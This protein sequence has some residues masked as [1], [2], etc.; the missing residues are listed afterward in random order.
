MRLAEFISEVRMAKYS[1]VDDIAGVSTDT[2]KEDKFLD[3]G[4][5]RY[6]IINLKRQ[7]QEEKVEERKTKLIYK[8]AFYMSNEEDGISESLQ[9]LEGTSSSLKECILGMEEYF[10]GN[11]EEAY[12]LLSENCD[13][14]LGTKKHFL[15]NKVYGLLLIKKKKYNK[16]IEVLK[17]A[18]ALCP[19]DI[20]CYRALEEAYYETFQQEKHEVVTDIIALLTE[21]AWEND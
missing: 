18:L 5:L 16:A 15:I 9:Y 12:E 1:I 20:E 4:Y 10:D 6:K 19:E 11:L 8:L 3:K 7:I 2:V 14:L 13:L 21:K 17:I